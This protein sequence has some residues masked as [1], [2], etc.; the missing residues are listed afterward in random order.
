M[1]KQNVYACNGKYSAVKRKENL[2]HGTTWMN[3]EDIMLSKISQTQKD[4]YC[5]IPLT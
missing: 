1:N 2:T 3:L 5:M 4:R